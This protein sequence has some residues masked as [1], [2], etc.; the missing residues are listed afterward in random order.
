M[1]D[2]YTTKDGDMLDAI[3]H[4]HYGFTDGSV[5]TVYNDPRN[6]TLSQYTT[7][8]TGLTVYLPPVTQAT[9]TTATSALW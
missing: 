5:E 7:L 3:C 8:P 4:N 1:T 6:K 2:T 9:K